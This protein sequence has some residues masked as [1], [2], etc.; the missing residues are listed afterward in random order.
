M[1]GNE[2]SITELERNYQ[3]NTKGNT[4]VI[5]INFM[6]SFQNTK[7]NTKEH[8]TEFIRFL[9]KFKGNTK[10]GFHE[11]HRFLQ[12]ILVYTQNRTAIKKVP[13]FQYSNIMNLK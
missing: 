5:P 11:L 6:D 4:K 12:I 10:E 8:S 1:N 2:G 7:G 9:P 13:L 3:T